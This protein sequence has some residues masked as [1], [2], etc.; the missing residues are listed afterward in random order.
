M[1]ALHVGSYGQPVI[2]ML[3]LDGDPWDLRGVPVSF[4]FEKPS[5]QKVT[6]QAEGGNGKATYITEKGLVT[7]GGMWTCEVT[8]DIDAKTR[9]VRTFSIPVVE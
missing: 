5:G 4:E 9:Y 3:S 1:D 7:E 2:V 8:I 6:V